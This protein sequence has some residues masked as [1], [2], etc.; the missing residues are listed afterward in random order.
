MLTPGPG[1]G[2]PLQEKGQYTASP[3][4]PPAAAAGD[5]R[6]SREEKY[7]KDRRARH[8]FQIVTFQLSMPWAIVWPG[9]PKPMRQ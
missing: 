5:R 4:P 6:D 3:P 8:R 9:M 2:L 1:G 7:P